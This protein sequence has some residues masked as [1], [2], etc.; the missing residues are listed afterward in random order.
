MQFQ[1]FSTDGI[2]FYVAQHLTA[3]SGKVDRIFVCKVEKI[4]MNSL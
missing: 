1:V 2:L 4:L 3:Q